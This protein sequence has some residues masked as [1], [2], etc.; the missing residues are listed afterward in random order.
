[1]NSKHYLKSIEKSAIATFLIVALVAVTFFVAEPKVGQ[2]V[3]SGPFTIKQTIT[4]EISF[5]TNASNVTMSG[6]LNGVTGGTANGTTTAV[7][8]TNNSAGYTMTI[9][10]ADNTT[11][12]AMLGE[13]TL[14]TAIRDY[15]ASSSE[16]TYGF[17]TA[18][19]SSVFGYSVTASTTSD[20]DASFKHDGASLCNTGSTVTP[21][22]CWME[23]K[24]SSFQIIN[25]GTAAT[26]GATTT[27]SFK[28]HVPNAPSPVLVTDVYTAT[29]TLTALNTP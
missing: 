5:T 13:S 23:P 1:M 7:V 22:V 8:T 26:A 12:N 20:L 19:S 15:P 24:T 6:N 11:D 3:D 18:S 16:P 27:I 9:A 4:G 17:Y 2:A 29:A 21:G 25:R 28:V 14:S 10:F